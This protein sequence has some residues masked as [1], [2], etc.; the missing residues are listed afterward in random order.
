MFKNLLIALILMLG[1]LMSVTVFAG[2]AEMQKASWE[3][4]YAACKVEAD[5]VLAD[6]EATIED[7]AFAQILLG[8]YYY[9]Q[10]EYDKSKI[11]NQKVL[12]DYPSVALRCTA[13]LNNIGWIQIMQKEY[14]KAILTNQKLIADYSYAPA[15]SVRFECARAYN[16]IGSCYDIQGET[17]KAKTAYRKLLIEYPEQVR[18]TVKVFDKVDFASMTDEEVVTILE[19]LLRATPSVAKNGAFLGRIKSDLEK[20]K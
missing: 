13:A 11:E 8:S 10:K 18:Q 12:D 4:D 9:Q 5:K 19:R 3:Q 7:K 1:M 14:D 20:F 6:S 17:E 2:F 15:D 16:R